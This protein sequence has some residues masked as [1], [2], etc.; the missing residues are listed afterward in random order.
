M[1]GRGLGHALR[2]GGETGH[3]RF[4]LR[5]AERVDVWRT[6]ELELRDA[7]NRTHMVAEEGK[8]Q[9]AL[10][11]RGAPGL[12][13]ARHLL[14]GVGRQAS[15]IVVEAPASAG[16]V[17]G[18]KPPRVRFEEGLRTAERQE[19]LGLSGLHLLAP[20][21]VGRTTCRGREECQVR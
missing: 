5:H 6:R 21:G 3:D 20:V 13:V 17:D 7:S 16:G 4:A 14:R 15:D 9:G 18:G 1:W 10:K 2:H 19:N 11:L 8:P 12:E